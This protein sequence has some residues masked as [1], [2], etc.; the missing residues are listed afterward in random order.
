VASPHVP[1]AQSALGLRRSATI[2]VIK[3]AD[4]FL[5]NGSTAAEG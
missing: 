2:V 4:P 5:Q 1:I 3:V